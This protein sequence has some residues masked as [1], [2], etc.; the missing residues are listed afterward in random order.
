[1]AGGKIKTIFFFE[2]SKGHLGVMRSRLKNDLA[3]S[4]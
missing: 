3:Q 4:A 1:V 2:V